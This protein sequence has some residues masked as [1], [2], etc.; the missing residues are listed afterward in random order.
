MWPWGDWPHLALLA[1]LLLLYLA[2]TFGMFVM[3]SRLVPEEPPRSVARATVV[4]AF[5]AMGG[6]GGGHGY[7]VCPALLIIALNLMGGG[8][9]RAIFWFAVIPFVVQW[10]ILVALFMGWS[11]WRGQWE[12]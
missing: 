8:D 1:G 11:R 4:A 10:L 5:L 7:I 2:A 9:T 12:I 3:V 6:A